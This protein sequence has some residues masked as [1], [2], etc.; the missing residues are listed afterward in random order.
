MRNVLP[1]N[2]LVLRGN[3]DVAAFISK[4]QVPPQ[5]R[6]RVS[7]A[8][9]N[10]EQGAKARC[11]GWTLIDTQSSRAGGPSDKLFKQGATA[12]EAREPQICSRPNSSLAVGNT[13]IGAW[14]GS[15]EVKWNATPTFR[16]TFGEKG[17]SPLPPVRFG[18]QP[19]V[20]YG[21]KTSDTDVNVRYVHFTAS[22]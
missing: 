6:G 15:G 8:K 5:G 14:V 21:T 18:D 1:D 22:V 12:S 3:W 11:S 17:F 20:A 13:D 19:L 9:N 10:S 7:G 2:F 16:G 4:E